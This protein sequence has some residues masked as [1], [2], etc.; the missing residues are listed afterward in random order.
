MSKAGLNLIN[1]VILYVLHIAI[2]KR[3]SKNTT[4]FCF[5]NVEKMQKI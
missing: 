1:L 2:R 3:L 4:A 5:V